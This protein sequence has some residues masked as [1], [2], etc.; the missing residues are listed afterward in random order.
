MYISVGLSVGLS[1]Y[2]STHSPIHPTTY[3]SILSVYLFT[4]AYTHTYL[5]QACIDRAREK[6][7]D[8]VELCGDS[9]MALK[10]CTD[11][12]PEYYGELGGGG[13]EY[14][15]DKSPPPE[16]APPPEASPPSN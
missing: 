16:V 7:T 12:H 5:W 11:K 3:P 8:F 6:D 13:D 4:H 14:D 9:T 10:D 2:L 1:V 15:A